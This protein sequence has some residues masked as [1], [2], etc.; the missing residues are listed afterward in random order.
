MWPFTRALSG[1]SE[2]DSMLRRLWP[3]LLSIGGLFDKQR[4]VSTF[5]RL[6]GLHRTRSTRPS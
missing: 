3:R 4:A 1:G 5:T 2:R 6:P